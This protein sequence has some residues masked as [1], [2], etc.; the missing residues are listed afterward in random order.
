[1]V[2]S[3]NINELAGALS[4]AQGVMANAIKDSSN[5]FFKSK[6]AD[7]TSVIEAIKEPLSTNGLSYSQIIDSE[8]GEIFVETI[9]M[10]TSGQ[11]LSSKFKLKL[12]KD[13]MQGMGSAITYARRY[14][15]QSISGLSA[16]DDDGESAV[17]RKP[18][19]NGI[20]SG[21]EM[22]KEA[23]ESSFVL[24]SD[25]QSLIGNAKI[26]KWDEEDV[27]KYIATLGYEIPEKGLPSLTKLDF[28]D[29]F[30]HFTTNKKV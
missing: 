27:R 4:K 25:M 5:P 8:N 1:M 14:A 13:D 21:E 20:K 6:Y 26:N 18:Q 29:V 22:L 15:L 24:K 30:K 12:S 28:Q 9:L 23:K 11:Y 17:G 10:H 16:E 7:L 19:V 2:K 3:E